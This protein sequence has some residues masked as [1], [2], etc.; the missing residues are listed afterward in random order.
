MNDQQQ[1]QA[2][3]DQN[4]NQ[5]ISIEQLNNAITGMTI[6]EAYDSP[7]ALQRFLSVNGLGLAETNHLMNREGIV[8]F[9]RLITLFP[10]T[11]EF[12]KFITDVNKTFGGSSMPTRIYFNISARKSLVSV[13]FYITRCLLVNMVPDVIDTKIKLPEF[14]QA[15]NWINFRDKFIELLSSTKGTTGLPLQY[16]I[17]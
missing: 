1:N 12:E 9:S 13:H 14:K 5:D 17:R 2:N 15:D 7:L 16:V 4:R 10:S 8:S 3:P 6:R 11:K